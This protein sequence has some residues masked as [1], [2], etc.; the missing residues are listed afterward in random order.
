M[1]FAEGK[2]KFS[3]EESHRDHMQFNACPI[4]CWNNWLFVAEKPSPSPSE[5][6]SPF[7][8]FGKQIRFQL[9]IC[10]PSPSLSLFGAER[11]LENWLA[12]L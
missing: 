1:R 8:P 3:K 2:M 6:P 10:Q 4:C 9:K 12:K 11:Q 5:K 7:P